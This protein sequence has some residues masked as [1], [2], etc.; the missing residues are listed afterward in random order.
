MNRVIKFRAWDQKQGGM[1]EGKLFEWFIHGKDSDME[2][3]NEDGSLPLTD[4]RFFF[5]DF[6]F[7]QFTGIL[8]K[9]GVECY[10]GDI[11]INQD[12]DKRQIVWAMYGFEMRLLTGER[13]SANVTWYFKFEII[14]NI[15]ANP[16]LLKL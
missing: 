9:N 8:D 6:V 16:D 3:P 15:Y 13:D 2:F 1:S 5:S 4:L 10:E 11:V 7:M 12:G 14:G